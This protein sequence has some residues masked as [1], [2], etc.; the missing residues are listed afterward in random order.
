MA[1]SERDQERSGGPC[2]L[3][4]SAVAVS[5]LM[6]LG[7]SVPAAA[8]ASGPPPAGET[9]AVAMTVDL[10]APLGEVPRLAVGGF[11]FANFMQVVG[12]EADFRELGVRSIRFPA[13]NLGD[14]R[15]RTPADLDV[16]KRH[17]LLLGRPEIVMQ[18]RLRGG[19]PQDAVAAARYAQAIGLPIRYW[20]IGNEP[21]LYPEGWT[22]E[23]YCTQFRAFV[24][25]LR[26]VVGDDVRFAGPAVSGG[27]G[28]MEWVRRFI[29]GCGDVVDVVTW[30]VYPTDGTA[31]DAVALGTAVSV[32]AEIEQVSRWLDDPASNPKGWRRAARVGLGITEFGLSWRTASF[33]H[34]ADLI[35]AL[36][37]AD[38]AAQAASQRLELAHYFAL[39][40]TG[41]HGVIDTAGFRRP[42][43]PALRMLRD[44]EGQALAVQVSSSGPDGSAVRAYAARRGDTVRVLAVNTDAVRLADAHVTFAGSDRSAWRLARL[45]QLTQES[46]DATEDAER[47]DGAARGASASDRIT[48]PPRSVTLAEYAREEIDVPESSAWG[49]SA[50]RSPVPVYRDPSQPVSKR[51][52]DLLARMTL[53]EKV[54]QMAQVDLTR[55]M[56]RGPWDR[57]PLNEEW[58]RRAIVEHHAGSV[59]S[60]GNSQPMPN[61]PETWAETANA[62]QRWAVER[63]RLGIPLLLAVDAV[64]GHA[65]VLGATVFPHQIGLA[66]TWD[67]E[68]VEQ[69]AAVTAE[70][71]RATGF[72]WNFSPVADVGRD[73]RWGRFYETF[74]EDPYLA[75]ELVAAS[76]RGLQEPSSGVGVLATLKHFVGYSQPQNGRDRSPAVIPERVLQEVFYPPFE[77]GIRAGART[78]MANSGSVNG[79]P[80]HASRHL[81]TDVLRDRLGFGGVVVT[82]WEDVGRLQSVHRVA[83]SIEEAV[84]LAVMAGI[85]VNMLPHDVPGF[86]KALV[87]LVEAG[88]VPIARIDEA[89]RRILT[90]KFELGLFESPYVEV[91]RARPAVEAG[92]DLARRAAAESITL[93]ENRDGLLP[94]AAPGLGHGTGSTVRSIL[95][96]GTHADDVAAQLGGWTAG[97][98][99]AS[100]RE[101][102]PAV[103]VLEGLREA[104]P[105]GV[106]VHH[107]PAPSGFVG[108]GDLDGILGE[109]RRADVVVA[110]VGEPPYAEG[111]GDAWEQGFRLRPEQEALLGGLSSTGTPL[112]VVLVA[113]R[114]LVLG[115]LVRQADALVMAYL[116]GSEAGRA[117]AD[118]IFGRVSPAGR[119]PF[120]WPRSPIQVPLTYDRVPGEPYDPLYPFGYGLS[121]TTFRYSDL[122]ATGP[123]DG[124][125]HVEIT[126]TNTGS[127]EADEV[128]QVYAGKPVSSVLRPVRKL[129][130]FRRV[131][132]KPGESARLAFDVPLDRLAVAPADD[133]A[134]TAGDQRPVIEP[135]LYQFAAGGLEASVVY[136]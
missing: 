90:V 94:L 2:L 53:P 15:D 122:T 98:Q 100:S 34:L 119:L 107:A 59:L 91:A 129:V 67:P 115:D 125:V 83:S 84:Q 60:G 73:W 3:A 25:A 69:A 6:L 104:A 117:V 70:A 12:F 130:A 103:T 109:A 96:T 65:S 32:T 136:R 113:G 118:V 102:P 10:A 24:S 120:S 128:V 112:V 92:R 76:V 74:G 9:L 93:L 85:D 75:G 47:R 68:L 86:T 87:G 121:Y 51:V 7:T 72:H 14:E 108:A 13:G 54:G 124:E 43:F 106:E 4:S 5:L 78:V 88:A 27:A 105:S 58:I 71:V 61:D 77:A 57:G 11:N 95:V 19:T 48:L 99:G 132:L 26:P 42:T 17:W 114:P 116:P 35:A 33:R 21:D 40:D 133:R 55:L 79:V 80:V 28:K 41:G 46:F 52:E 36:W 45:E 123:A 63:T 16:L 66:A 44:F 50:A 111:A 39:Q 110:V 56:G 131:H 89:V 101:L 18:A 22:P 31:P 30:H 97:W 23:E 8:G 49:E 134:G 29:E 37:A 135:G 38:V 1:S 64:H 82:D 126:V 127:I 62:L 81:L 20:E